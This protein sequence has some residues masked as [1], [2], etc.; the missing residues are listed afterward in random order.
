[1]QFNITE[2]GN[3]NV[4]NND[5][6][7]GNA[8]ITD[9]DK[10]LNANGFPHIIYDNFL[11][12]S[13]AKIINNEIMDLYKSGDLF[14]RYNN[15]FEEKYTLRDK[16]LL[17]KNLQELFNDL[18]NNE[19]W[20][21]YLKY[22]SDTD[23]IIDTK[24]QYWG[25][26]IFKAGDKLDIHV[27]A[28]IHPILNEKKFLTFGIYL[29]KDNIINGELE[30]WSG[31]SSAENAPEIY[32]CIKKI[33]PIF[34]R[35]VL[36]MNTDYSWHGAPTPFKNQETDQYRIF[37]TCSYLKKRTLNERNDL[38]NTKTRAYFAKIKNDKENIIKDQLRQLRAS[39]N[40]SQVYNMTKQGI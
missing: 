6:V 24:K 17:P 30:L 32:E 21:N 8:N 23:I 7:N 19:E 26:H 1:M 3:D 15:P 22:I 35:A 29:S 28:G 31:D 37:V 10:F 13:R 16:N 5:N 33:K 36:F 40:C 20:L 18:N 2:S 11:N 9:K 27:D 34:N 12:N 39:E 38:K 4:N 14:D 25:V